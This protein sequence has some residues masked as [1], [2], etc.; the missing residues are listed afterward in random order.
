MKGVLCAFGKDYILARSNDR[1][2]AR[3]SGDEIWEGADSVIRLGW[4]SGIRREEV[5]M[6]TF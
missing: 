5:F 4:G 3:G 1:R 6:H 2:T